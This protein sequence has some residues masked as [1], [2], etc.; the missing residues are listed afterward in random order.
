MTI[1]TIQDA[2]K[3]IEENAVAQGKFNVSACNEFQFN[4]FGKTISVY[5]R[6][7]YV[8]GIDNVFR[9]GLPNQSPNLDKNGYIEDIYDHTWLSAINHL[10]FQLYFG[11]KTPSV[12]I[13]YHPKMASGQPYPYLEHMKVYIY[14]KKLVQ[15]LMKR[16]ESGDYEKVTKHRK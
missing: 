1:P 7:G 11:Q 15:L 14:Q 4:Y 12:T 5:Y 8:L 3:F 10:K 13:S 6:V 2:I 9:F 16:Y